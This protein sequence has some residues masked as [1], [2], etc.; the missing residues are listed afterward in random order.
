MTASKWYL[1]L[2]VNLQLSAT[3]CKTGELS[4]GVLQTKTLELISVTADISTQDAVNL[5]GWAESSVCGYNVPVRGCHQNEKWESMTLGHK[6]DWSIYI[7][8]IPTFQFRQ[9][10]VHLTLTKSHKKSMSSVLVRNRTTVSLIS[11][12]FRKH[13]F[14]QHQEANEKVCAGPS[15]CNKRRGV[16]FF[17]CHSI[18]LLSIQFLNTRS[19]ISNRS[20][21]F[22]QNPSGPELTRTGLGGVNSEVRGQISSGGLQPGSTD[23]H[24]VRGVGGHG[25]GDLTEAATGALLEQ[26]ATFCEWT[27]QD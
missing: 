10:R 2:Q 27:E 18:G 22:T 21:A 24:L 20:S 11:D 3:L 26:I 14:I 7:P 8:Y 1:Q 5:L 15:Q 23:L 19:E 17:L 9:H 13:F 4:Q 25:N 16:R 6:S 12:I